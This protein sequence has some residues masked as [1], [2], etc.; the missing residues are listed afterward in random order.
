M[1]IHPVKQHIAATL[2][3]LRK[4]E[5][6]GHLEHAPRYIMSVL[7]DLHDLQDASEA[8]Y[9]VMDDRQGNSVMVE[10]LEALIADN[11]K[12]IERHSLMLSIEC[13]T[14]ML[15]LAADAVGN[16]R[17]LEDIAESV[18]E[19][20]DLR[21][22]LLTSNGSHTEADEAKWA[23]TVAHAKGLTPHTIH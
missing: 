1:R 13:H 14:V 5:A 22:S 16:G 3:D 15:R 10:K 23:N 6:D 12:P 4:L 19:V 2:H 7:E 8:F 21:L 20:R 11:L 9:R 18:R 17:D